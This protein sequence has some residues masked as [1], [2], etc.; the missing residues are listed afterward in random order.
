MDRNQTLT[1]RLRL[2][3]IQVDLDEKS[4]ILTLSVWSIFVSIVGVTLREVILRITTLGVWANYVSKVDAALSE[5]ILKILSV[6]VISS[7]SVPGP[8]L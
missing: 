8:T 4:R 1:V 3:L 7:L 6:R 5:A 2:G